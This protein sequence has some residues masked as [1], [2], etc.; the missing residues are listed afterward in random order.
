MPIFYWNYHNSNYQAL[1]L[2]LQNIKFKWGSILILP[3][4]IQK[5]KKKSISST[6]M[7]EET[8]THKLELAHGHRSVIQTQASLN[9][10]V[11]AFNSH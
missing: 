10:N 11:R 6:L 9:A 3:H 4:F 2:S 8:K 5:K 1:L 7:F